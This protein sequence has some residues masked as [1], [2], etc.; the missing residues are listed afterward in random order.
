MASAASEISGAAG[1][2]F[3]ASGF[4]FA[5][6]LRGAFAAVSAG[7]LPALSTVSAGASP[8]AMAGDASHQGT[9]TGSAGT[10]DGHDVA[11]V[12]R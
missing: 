2:S 12:H 7:A 3:A 1:F 11:S 6:L 10:D 8:E 5:G 4:S 9:F